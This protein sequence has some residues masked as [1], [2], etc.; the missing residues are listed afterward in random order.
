MIA[1]LRQVAV[2]CVLPTLQ[3]AILPGTEGYE[4]VAM[5]NVGYPAPDSKPLSMHGEWKSVGSLVTRVE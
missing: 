5:I 3:R 2:H 4:M 1:F